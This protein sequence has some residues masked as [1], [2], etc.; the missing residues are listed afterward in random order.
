M[1]TPKQ[2]MVHIARHIFTTWKKQYSDWT[3][4]TSEWVHKQTLEW[5]NRHTQARTLKP[6]KEWRQKLRNTWTSTHTHNKWKHK[7]PNNLVKIQEVLQLIRNKSGQ[8]SPLTFETWENYTN[9]KVF[10]ITD[11]VLSF[12]VFPGTSS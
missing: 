10:L 5:T 4:K 1:Y 7:Q 12:I 9:K 2:I 8:V 6:T 3:G 11:S